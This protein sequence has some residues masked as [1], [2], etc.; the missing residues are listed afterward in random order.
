MMSLNICSLAKNWRSRLNYLFSFSAI[1]C[2]F[3]LYHQLLILAYV[4]NTHHLHF[5]HRWRKPHGLSSQN[6]F[7]G[8]F[9]KLTA[10]RVR[11]RDRV[12]LIPCFICAGNFTNRLFFVLVRGEPSWNEWVKICAKNKCIPMILPWQWNTMVTPTLL[13]MNDQPGILCFYPLP[14]GY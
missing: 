7:L 12:R 10:D 5:W 6:G 3:S 1:V 9:G 14:L 11:V 13:V 4:C 2:I 8:D